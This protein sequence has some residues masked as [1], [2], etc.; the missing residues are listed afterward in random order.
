M[1]RSTTPDLQ[2]LHEV[3]S[4][5]AALEIQVIVLAVCARKFT[6]SC[7]VI[8]PVKIY[9]KI[10]PAGT[11]IWTTLGDDIWVVLRVSEAI[12]FLH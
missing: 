8:T 2:L 4:G 10:G 9:N 7:R 12:P 11:R 6:S 3:S 5:N 1:E